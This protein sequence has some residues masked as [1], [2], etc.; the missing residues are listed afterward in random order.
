MC[1]RKR[2]GGVAKALEIA[3][4]PGVKHLALP[5]AQRARKILQLAGSVS[6]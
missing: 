4:E 3:A 1:D 6:S 2:K 5:A